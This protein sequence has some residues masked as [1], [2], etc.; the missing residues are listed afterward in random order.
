MDFHDIQNIVRWHVKAVEFKATWILESIMNSW[1]LCGMGL[2]P[3]P[4][5]VISGLARDWRWIF[6][7]ATKL[8][9]LTVHVLRPGQQCWV[10]GSNKMA[11]W[12]FYLM[13]LF[14]KLAVYNLASTG[15]QQCRVCQTPIQNPRVPWLHLLKNTTNCLF[16][17][18]FQKFTPGLQKYSFVLVLQFRYVQVI[19]VLAYDVCS[20]Y[21]FDLYC[22]YFMHCL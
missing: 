17:S 16:G 18:T 13:V 2:W 6:Q 15:T 22:L 19:A 3:R 21:G 9:Y 11:R 1:T 4:G 12:Y 5:L 10:C 20:R 7:N 14:I 8:L